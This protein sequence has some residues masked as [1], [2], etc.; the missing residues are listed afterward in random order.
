MAGDL[1][2]DLGLGIL[3]PT[4]ST[5]GVE[6][7]APQANGEG[8]TRPR[9]DRAREESEAESDEPGA[10]GEHQLDRLA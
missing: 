8:K 6:G 7:N 2:S 3:A 10:G 9:R 5:R 4:A 1:S